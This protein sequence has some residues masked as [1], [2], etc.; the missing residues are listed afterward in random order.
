MEEI[1]S[2][3]PCPKTVTV[4]RNPPR[5]A[6][7][8]PS[9]MAP[10]PIMPL[11]PTSDSL[12]IPS[13]PTEEIL[14]IQLPPNPNPNNL[15]TSD[16]LSSTEPENLRVFLRIR[17]LA[18]NGAQITKKQCKNAWP[19]SKNGSR[20]KPKKKTEICVSATDCHSVT[21]SPPASLKEVKRVKTEVYGGF[22]EVFSAESTQ[23]EVYAKMVNPLVEDFLK[24]KCG[25]LAALGPSGSG[26]TH[27]VF[28]SPRE[29]GMIPLALR[30]IFSETEGCEN[31]SSKVFYLSMFEISSERGKVEGIFDLFQDTG[32]AC[33][34][35]TVKGVKEVTVSNVQQAELLVTN[36]MSKRSTART[37][38]N[39]QSSRSQCIINIRSN[40]AFLT[41]VDLAGAERV[42]RTG[43]QGTRLMESNFIN[44]TSMV[45][46]LCLRSLLEHQK[47]PKRPL[48]KHF[49]NSL[50]TRYLRDY[51]EGKKRMALIL[52]VKSGV[53]D[54]LD[55]SFLLRQASPYMKIKYNNAEEPFNSIST[56]RSFQAFPRIE[57]LKRMKL[58]SIEACQTNEGN[59]AGD[60]YRFLQEEA[61]PKEIKEFEAQDSLIHPGTTIKLDMNDGKSL[62]EG[63]IELEK[64]RKNVIMQNFAKA[65]W[66]VLKQYKGK[67]EVAE[68]QIQILT[69]SL[70][71]EK[72][73][74]FALETELKDL[75]SNL[76][77]NNHDFEDLP[78]NVGIAEDPQDKRVDDTQFV[79][80]DSGSDSCVG[81]TADSCSS[82]DGCPLDTEEDKLNAGVSSLKLDES[83]SIANQERSDTS[84]NNAGAVTASSIAVEDFEEQGYQ[85]TNQESE[86]FERN[87]D[88]AED[89][90]NM[91][92]DDTQFDRIDSDSGPSKYAVSSPKPFVGITNDSCSSVE[93]SQSDSERD[94]KRTDQPAMVEEGAEFA[95]RCDACSEIT[96]KPNDSSSPG[97]LNAEKPKRRLLPASSILLKNISSLEFEDEYE[98]PKGGRGEK[99]LVPEE[100]NRTQG[101][102]SLLRLL[103]TNLHL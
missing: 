80:N 14:S 92:T 1:S 67:L 24:G 8:T 58:S 60:G 64:E 36:G 103:R 22:S 56:K 91:G 88:I 61:L 20:E 96:S 45:F 62:G 77:V 13:F 102:I 53:E 4:R 42:L 97:A 5:R 26:K 31:Q 43:N 47:N 87:A 79:R 59:E 7:P 68:N 19:K 11:S 81:S 27:T 55:T 90:K 21:V 10:V 75:K 17:P 82:V 76:L 57:R 98:K 9:S 37:N 41:V 89:P 48:Q 51:L 100:R 72:A 78:R 94:K 33:M 35:S 54:Y 69:K 85:F 52:T 84:V 32:D 50:L 40:R 30:R 99:K 28:G 70:A 38:S 93:G 73:Q 95:K 46:G 15:S 25:M 65:I 49:Q 39:N 34:Q 86:D 3:P 83:E 66:N 29:P 18:P 12:K 101:S 44:N 63:S 23:D 16:S 71:S 6:R 74:R 2:P